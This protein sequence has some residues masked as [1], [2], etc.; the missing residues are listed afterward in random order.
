M[1]ASESI[2]IEYSYDQLPYDSHPYEKTHPDHLAT[3]AQIFGLQAPDPAQSRVLEIGCASGGNLIPLAIALPE[4]QFL[5]FDLS[6]KELEEGQKLIDQLGLTN[7]QLE[8]CDILNFDRPDET[9]D[10][11]IC[12]GVF[13]WVPAEARAKIF[14]ICQETLSENGL[15]YISY[16]TFPGWF[17]RGMVRQML[18]FHARQFDDP[19]TQVEQARAL[20]D[21]LNQAASKYDPTYH[22]LLQ[23]EL[24][25]VRNRQ[26]SY[27]YH[28]HLE[29][30]NEPMF[31]YQ[32]M[33]QANKVGLRYLCETQFSEM[34]PS[35][36]S[37]EVTQTLK[38]LSSDI[39]HA[40]QYLDF[41]RNRTF[42]RTLL[43]RKDRELQ[44]D[45]GAD[46]LRGL[47]IRSSLKLPPL[48]I[49]L[50]RP[51]DLGFTSPAGLTATISSPLLKQ[52]LAAI[53][54]RYPNYVRFDDLPGLISSQDSPTIRDSS[55]LNQDYEELASMLLQLWG[56]DLIEIR[57]A[58]VR[59]AMSVPNSPK[60]TSLIL[61]QLENGDYVTN[62][63][64]EMIQLND[65]DRHLLRCLDRDAAGRREY[66]RERIAAKE[67]VVSTY[68]EQGACEMDNDQ[69]DQLITQGLQRLVDQALLLPEKK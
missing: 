30:D 31:F 19:N 49:P 55:K 53:C 39:I 59:Q 33:E 9:F 14:Q 17:M 61:S 57:S 3:M 67:L 23:R 6:R 52:G 46:Q 65:M 34:I 47:R 45:L 21:F 63:K 54:Q 29:E 10:Y 43:C 26:N 5:G 32:F 11:I 51:G 50:D 16:N 48:S 66:F 2:E 41:L 12:H 18:C 37:P 42:R 68:D 56:Q 64:H 22:M 60:T 28:E 15:A 7:I 24:E 20:L 62:L 8:H 4:S 35:Q 36:F 38:K 13:S 40:E 69:L 25:I 44:R 27:L 58:P 1:S